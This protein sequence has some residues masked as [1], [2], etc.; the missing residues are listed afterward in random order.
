MEER[1]ERGQQ[2]P[3]EGVARGPK[4]RVS[5]ISPVSAVAFGKSS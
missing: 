3:L 5:N 2:R 4:T 1:L